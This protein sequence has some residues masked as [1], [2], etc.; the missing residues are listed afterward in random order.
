MD[1]QNRLSTAKCRE[2][3]TLKRVGRADTQLRA[4]W[5]CGTVTGERDATGT[6]RGEHQT[7]TTDIQ[8]QG[9]CMVKTNPHNT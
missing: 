7:S 8:A 9:T 1:W 6:E 5:T 2:K 3:A 4:K